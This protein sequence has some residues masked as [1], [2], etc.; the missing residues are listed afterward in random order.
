MQNG[1]N[2][3]H[4]QTLQSVIVVTVLEQHSEEKKRRGGGTGVEIAM[5]MCIYSV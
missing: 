1:A 3:Q 2:Q 5:R 4:S